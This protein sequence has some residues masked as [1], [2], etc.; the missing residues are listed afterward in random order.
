MIRIRPFHLVHVGQVALA[1]L[2]LGVS[3]L[4]AVQM[5]DVRLISPINGKPFSALVVPMVGAA[6]VEEDNTLADMGADDD[7]C[8]HSS[9][10]NEYDYYIATCPYSYFSA[11]TVEWDSRNGRFLGEISP[12]IKGWVDKEF[13]SNR[14]LESNNAFKLASSQAKATGQMPPERD[15]FVMSQQ[16]IPLHR[17]YFCALECYE[18]RGARAAVL[19]KIALTGSWA[20]RV[21]FDQP[22][23]SDQLAGGIEEINDRIARH[24]QDGD[25]FD[26]KKWTEVYGKIFSKPEVK[27]NEAILIA[28]LVYHG[29][30]VRAGDHQQAIG[31]LD[32]LHDR[33][34]RVSQGA[35]LLKSLVRERRESYRRY[36]SLTDLAATKFIEAVRMEEFSRPRLPEVLLVVAESL[37]RTDHLA[38]AAQWY[39]CLAQ[40]AETQPKLRADIRAEGKS[41]SV[42]APYHLQLG[43]I[44]DLQLI[45]LAEAGVVVAAVPQGASAPLLNAILFEGFG[46]PEFKNP[47]WKPIKDATQKECLM[48][49]NQVGK[50][51]LEFKLRLGDWPTSLDDMWMR[52]LVRDRNLYNRFHCPVSGEL[53][54]YE[55]QS[56]EVPQR[57]ALLVT[58]IA[59]PTSQGPRY[60]AYLANDHVVWSEQPIKP[61]ELVAK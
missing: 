42:E 33:F 51:V 34:E 10:I 55:R 26:L 22:I 12:D 49:L 45:R 5:Q 29:F 38:D 32:S 19:A 53:L 16:A 46:T 18:K 47:A 48:I 2:A 21:G 25:G 4:A 30:L 59:I 54:L 43:W 15:A 27:T 50:S 60:G 23:S 6:R 11:L 13:N 40:M 1:L 36:R 57:T 52:D 14:Q 28:G 3:D 61:G 39:L 9:G 17:K 58:P 8:R 56:G 41:P 31:V 20:M 44:A 24:I 7:G 35:E 37:R